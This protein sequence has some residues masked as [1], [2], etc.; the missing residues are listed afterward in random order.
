MGRQAKGRKQENRIGNG[1]VTPVQ[2]AFI[3]D[4]YLADNNFSQSRSLFRTEA[5]SLLAN[6]SAHEAPKGLLTLGAMLDEYIHLKEQKVIL[7]QE[8]CQLEQEKLRVH[9][10]L[11]G[12]QDAM[13]AY[14]NSGVGVSCSL[15]PPPPH[16]LVTPATA[17]RM[18]VSPAGYPPNNTQI[19]TSTSTPGKL[20]G[21]PANSL[22]PT[23]TYPPPRK[24]KECKNIQD[25]AQT[26]KRSCNPLPKNQPSDKGSEVAVLSSNVA[27]V[28]GNANQCSTLESSPNNHVGD[29]LLAQKSSVAKSLFNQSFESP[30]SGSCDPRTPPRATSSQS[31]KSIS[32]LEDISSTAKSNPHNATQET[33]PAGCTVI[34]SSKTIII[35]PCKQNSCFSIERNRCMFTSPMKTNTKKQTVRDHVKG[36]LDFDCSDMQTAENLNSEGNTTPES[37]D[38]GF[39]DLDL[40]NLD[41]FGPH[42]TLSELLNDFDIECGEMDYTFQGTLDHVPIDAVSSCTLQMQNSQPCEPMINGLGTCQEFIEHSSS[43]AE[44]L[45]GKGTD[46]IASVRSITKRVQLLSPGI[47]SYLLTLSPVFAMTPLELI[48]SLI[49]Y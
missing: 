31:D 17:K 40:P 39:F 42:F 11:K 25:A 12:M 28:Q 4:R 22:T 35:S 10:L 13:N 46:S 38:G 14:N 37:D 44:V 47:L 6:S 15:P 7:D 16:S 43:A 48:E 3:V 23:A 18:F 9:A 26:T 2:V 36:R 8:K 34:S 33:T 32:P 24:R 45:T 21:E 41:A 20:N 30:K 49:C 29:G 5:S 19:M 1:K 27:D